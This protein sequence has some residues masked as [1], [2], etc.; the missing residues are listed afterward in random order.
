[1]KNLIVNADD[2]GAD[3]SRNEGIFEAIDAGV[4]TSV[5]I[6]ANGTAVDSALRGIR[7]RRDCDVSYGIHINLSEGVPRSRGLRLLT[8][9]EVR[10][11]G[12]AAA[13]ALFLPRGDYNLETEILNEMTAQ[14]E[15]LNRAGVGIRHLDGHQHVHVFP[16]VAPVAAALARAYRIPWIRMPSEALHADGNGGIPGELLIEAQRFAVL[17]ETARQIFAKQE[18]KTTDHFRGLYLKNR[19]DVGRLEKL[20]RGL[21]TGLTELMVHPGRDPGD[22]PTG[23]FAPFSTEARELELV[24]LTDPRFRRVLEETGVTLTPFP[25]A[26]E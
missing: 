16:A 3:E 15:T 21:P 10:F 4:V 12:K 20:V 6:L 18:L 9:S 25:H 17:A 23:P 24:A 11:M 22:V 5:S 2:L 26:E 14:I 8:G 7:S 13:H 1:M 19:L